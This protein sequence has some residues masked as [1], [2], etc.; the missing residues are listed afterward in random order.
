MKKLS[1]LALNNGFIDVR[2]HLD[3]IVLLT[4]SLHEITVRKD[5]VTIRFNGKVHAISI[6]Q[7]SL[8][9]INMAKEILQ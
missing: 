4:V 1:K 7:Q 2:R 3:T 5:S 6:D 8:D 9:I